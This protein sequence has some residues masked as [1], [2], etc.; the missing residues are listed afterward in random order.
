[1]PHHNLY[2][3]IVTAW[4]YRAMGDIRANLNVKPTGP[5]RGH[6]PDGKQYLIVHENTLPQAVQ[7]MELSGYEY[8]HAAAP[9]AHDAVL[10][11]RLVGAV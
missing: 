9:G 6:G 7:G 10:D 1:M 11:S 4:I 5:N 8:L 3:L 2:H